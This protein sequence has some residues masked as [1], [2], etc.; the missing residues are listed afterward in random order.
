MLCSRCK[1]IE[2]K[3]GFKQCQGC[4][5]S[6]RARM[7][8]LYSERISQGL[9]IGCGQLSI[10][11]KI[12]CLAC[13]QNVAKY[14]SRHRKVRRL[15]GICTCGGNLIGQ[16]GQCEKCRLA[17]KERFLKLKIDAFNAYGGAICACKN[18]PERLNPRVE[19]L[20]IDHINGGGN[21]HRSLVGHGAKFYRWLRDN[22]Y[23]PGYRVLCMN[24]NWGSRLLGE[25]P[26]ELAH[27]N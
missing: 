12:R 11:G 13:A 18:C 26:H 15:E 8:Q 19:F 17:S 20:T 4:I 27:V 5:D 7:R 16:K 6:K 9:C 1:S 22:N 14:Y 10:P 25:C 3:I 24:C 21:R 23:P 2:A